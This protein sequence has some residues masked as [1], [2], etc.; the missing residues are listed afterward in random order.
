MVAS[1]RTTNPTAEAA[2]APRAAIYCRVSTGPQEQDGTS[3]E[4]QEASC[5]AYAAQQG[6]AV[7]G[8]WRD[9]YTATEYRAR[10]GLTALRDAVRGGG[11]DVVL[12]HALDRLSRNQT[13]QFGQRKIFEC[14][15]EL[16][17][18]TASGAYHHHFGHHYSP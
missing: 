18:W 3:L 16:A 6:W 1:L 12:C 8:V 14:A 2:P 15:A 10:P 13:T 7:V 11:A 17:K 9:A 5:R 4:T